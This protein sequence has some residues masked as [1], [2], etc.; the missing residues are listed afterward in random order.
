MAESSAPAEP[1]KA[2]AESAEPPAKARRV[3]LDYAP[4]ARPLPVRGHFSAVLE[5]LL[6][7]P[8]ASADSLRREV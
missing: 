7:D 4:P 5:D 3:E 2:L 1:A 8:E 6:R